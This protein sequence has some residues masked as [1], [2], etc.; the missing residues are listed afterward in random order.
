[1]RKIIL[2]LAAGLL[3]LAGC[4]NIVQQEN[5]TD[6]SSG[7]T[8]GAFLRVTAETEGFAARK[9]E[10]SAR[11]ALPTIDGSAVTDSFTY[12]LKGTKEGGSEETLVSGVSLAKLKESLIPVTP[13]KWSFTLKAE[14]DG[15]VFTG[16]LSD[17]TITAGDNELSF[18]ISWDESSLS[19]KGSL[20]FSLDWS[21]AGLNSVE[22]AAGTLF[23][24]D[25]DTGTETETDYTESSGG[26]TLDKNAHT[27]TYSLSD[28]PAGVYMIKIS[29]YS[30]AEKTNLAG[31]WRELAVI[32]GG[33][34]SGA[35]RVM[36]VFVKHAATIDPKTDGGLS[37]ITQKT[38]SV[39]GIVTLT[40]NTDG[41]YTLTSQGMGTSVLTFNG[42]YAGGESVAVTY[43]VS[44][45]DTGELTVGSPKVVY[46]VTV[47]G[48]IEHGTV[49]AKPAPAAAGETVTLTVTPDS[50]YAG[51]IAIKNAS[52]EDISSSVSLSQD[53]EDTTKWTFTMPEG[54][55]TVSAIFEDTTPF[56]DT[57]KTGDEIN[58][59]LKSKLNSSAKHFKKSI[60]RNASATEYLDLNNKIP[61]W[62]DSI[63]ETIYYY[64]PASCTSLKMNENSSHMFNEMKYLTSIEINGFDTSAVTNM[65]AMFYGCLALESL[66]LSNFNTSKVENMYVMFAN[67]R[68]LKSLDLSSF[69]TSNVAMMEAMFESCISLASLNLGDRFHTSNVGHMSRMFKGCQELTTLDVS[70]FDTSAALYMQGMFWGCSKLTTLN[71]SGFDTS[72]VTDM[73]RM[74]SGCSKLTTLNVS[75][76]D[77]SNVTD[78]GY[79]FSDCSV[80]E[81]LDLS[82]FN[83]SSVTNMKGMFAECSALKSLDLGDSFDTG[84]VTDMASMFAGCSGL[85]S[86]DVTG[87]DTSSVTDM[88]RMFAGCSGLTSL[89]VTGF[90]T[91]KVT[92][93][94]YIFWGCSSLKTI[95][96]SDIF[97]TTNININNYTGKDCFSGCTSLVGESGTAYDEYKTSATYARIDGGES[98]PGY[99]TAKATT[100]GT[101]SKPDAV[102]D[103]VFSDGS[104]TPY[105]TDLTLSEAQKKAAVAVIYYAGSSA[106][107]VLG[108]KM[109][110][111]GLK[112]T[113]ADNYLAWAKDDDVNGYSTNI[114]AIQCEPSR[115]EA[116]TATFTG[117][118][119]GS[120]NWQALCKAVSDED[121]SGNYPAWEWVNA[122][123]T[124]A[125][126]TDDYASGWYLP[127]VAELSMLYRAK[128]TVNS[129]LEAAGGTK[130][131]DETYR[132]SSQNDFYN[133]YA[134][135]VGF[136]DGYISINYKDSVDS[137]CAVRAFSGTDDPKATAIGIKSKPDAVGDIVFSDGSATPYTSELT[138]TEEQKS[139]AV[140]VIFYAGSA[141][142]TLGAK[143]L[144]VGLKNATGNGNTLAW[145]RYTSP[146][147]KAEGYSTNITTIQCTPV[148][149]E[150]GAVA[151]ATFT[152]DLDGSDNWKAL[153]DV[154][155]DEDKS[156]NYPAW[157][158]VNAYA[159]TTAN[160]TGDYANGWYLPTVAELSML[161]RVKDTVNSALEK[162]GGTKIDDVFYWSSSLVSFY[163]SRALGVLFDD[164]ILDAY[165]KSIG[166]SVC[167]VRAF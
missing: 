124:T 133:N 127:T 82:S 70:R 68:A 143:T 30:D 71:V 151:T 86:L 138:L 88:S 53:S 12:T 92:N 153:C 156:G 26:I 25:P 18:T 157:E 121:T 16:T 84:N 61:V 29:F 51:A 146:D 78:M 7:G 10:A 75:G 136:D 160:L 63:S 116:A 34:K 48:G 137:V 150:K 67:C 9:E 106:E 165:D 110:G 23:A 158:W 5:D 122:Y 85:T 14:K 59:I 142:D 36:D 102:G 47:A 89:D 130:I 145:A 1:M 118:L 98:A 135:D 132:S 96:A 120:D 41:T 115:E 3:L 15:T 22:T 21:K 69:D 35:S 54:T 62:Y 93:M 2:L 37:G 123:A 105:S 131:A 19:G 149:D 125:N 32:T 56:D 57:L 90:D 163:E 49:T 95:Y 81:S 104:A 50:G 24:Y 134:W 109:L 112:N 129:A 4:S 167:T 72:K 119:D 87:F 103:I 11:T 45:S 91:S 162:A 128:D 159:T 66:D 100:I 31:T 77:T 13:G 101:K 27:V 80:L 164:G 154:V 6:S 42:T 28:V 166:K 46:S 108:A 141:S 155:N 113:G 99:F 17:K 140:A 44:V 60:T 40:E 8:A 38:S 64:I 58:W 83:T 114:T 65:W 43:N 76:F 97:V 147:D 73:S 161:Y 55:V 139:K 107:D 126:L 39:D 94:Q 144:G 33:Q 152:G 74:F 111:V 52:G 79:M 117:D 148:V 20:A